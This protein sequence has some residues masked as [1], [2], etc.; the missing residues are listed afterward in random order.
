MMPRGYMITPEPESGSK[1]PPYFEVQMIFTVAS[2][3]F[4]FMAFQSVGG[5]TGMAD[6]SLG[7][8]VKS[9]GDD[10]VETDV[11]ARFVISGTLDVVATGGETFVG[12]FTSGLAAG[13]FVGVFVTDAAFA[14]FESV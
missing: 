3:V 7:L 9:G 5:G 8:R 11:V 14:V 6:S 13:F 2:R 1:L 10:T 12:G 4:W